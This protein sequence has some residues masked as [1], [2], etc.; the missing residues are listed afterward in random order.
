MANF[1]FIFDLDETLVTKDII[2]VVSTE[3]FL[4]KK[5]DRIYTGKDT[6]DFKGSNLPKIVRDK[7]NEAFCDPI[8]GCLDKAPIPGAYILLYY[9]LHAK[10]HRLG[11]VTSRPMS[12]HEPTKYILYRDFYNINFNLGIHFSNKRYNCYEESSKKEILSDIRARCGGFIY[13]D[14]NYSHCK[15][16]IKAGADKAYLISNENTGWNKDIK[17]DHDNIY[18]IPSVVHLPMEEM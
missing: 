7:M 17:I 16:A 4:D 3:L 2:E 18:R 10:H 12:L 1:N 5:I 11:I 6:K 15:E 8:K 14:D 13:F 9:L